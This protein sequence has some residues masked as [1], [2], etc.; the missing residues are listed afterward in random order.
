MRPLDPGRWL[1]GAINA[2]VVLFLLLPI[3][4]VAVFAVN[5]TP[6]IQF[7]PVGVSLRWFQKFFAS[8][9]F[10]QAIQLSLSVAAV[11]AVLATTL[12]ATAAL[13][14]ARGRL[15]EEWVPSKPLT[16]VTGLGPFVLTEHTSGQRLVF[17]RNPRYFR[18]D[19]NGTALPYLD[20][21]VLAVVPDQNTEALRLE[22]GEIDLMANGEIRPQDYSAFK[23]RAEA[24][25]LR[26]LDV[27]VTM[28][29]LEHLA[30]PLAR[31]ER[32]GL[33]ELLRAQRA[34]GEHGHEMRLHLEHAARHVEEFLPAAL[35]LSMGRR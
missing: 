14:L 10:M 25:S 33:V 34:V 18:V 32:R 16:D 7:P 27:D 12:G 20:R 28:A 29:A 5:P 22:A 15:A 1:Y 30:R 21:L 31:G 19:A 3:A 26:L 24:G 8:R 9:D 4:I 2:L 11:V 23:R 13:A 6:F 17:E 35:G